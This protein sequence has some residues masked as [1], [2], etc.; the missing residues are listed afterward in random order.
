MKNKFYFIM[1]FLLVISETVIAEQ[2]LVLERKNIT[3]QENSPKELENKKP[4]LQ[5]AL[6]PINEPLK[7]AKLDEREV[8][9]TSN[10]EPDME[11]DKTYSHADQDP[12]SFF[13]MGTQYS[14]TSTSSYMGVILPFHG[15]QMGNGYVH[16]LFLDYQEYQYNKNTTTIQA[17]A[18]GLSYSIGY[19]GSMDAGHYGVFMGM[20]LKDTNLSPDD[21]DNKG[22][23][24]KT[25]PI[26]GVELDKNIMESFNAA[27]Y[28][29][30]T[31]GRRAYWSKFKLK[32]NSIPLHPG[33]EFTIQG[34]AT[35]TKRQAAISI[36]DLDIVGGDY[37]FNISAGYSEVNSTNGKFLFGIEMGTSF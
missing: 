18:P 11:A 29:N 17:K 31:L 36:N 3:K 20:N 24:F 7:Q 19:Q 1:S 28:A 5:P 37:R 22:S 32:S 27:M 26:V 12:D 34:D 13:I 8:I 9:E 15:S 14:S 6:N 30:Y 10:L 4:E 33:V 21:T 2:A 25:D 35:Y 16:R 23:G